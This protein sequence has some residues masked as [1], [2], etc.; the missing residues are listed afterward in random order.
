MGA[1]L[2]RDPRWPGARAGQGD[3][4]AGSPRARERPGGR[5]VA[6]VLVSIVVSIPACH[7]GDRG[8][9]PRRGG[10][11]PFLVAAVAL[12]PAAR[13]PTAL[14]LVPPSFGEAPGR[15]AR[16]SH[17]RP[18]LPVRPSSPSPLWSPGARSPRPSEGLLG[19]PTALPDQSR[20]LRPAGPPGRPRTHPHRLPRWAPR[21]ATPPPC[22]SAQRRDACRQLGPV[23]PSRRG[24]W[25]R[26]APGGEGLWP[27]GCGKL[28]APRCPLE[29]RAEAFA[30]RGG[31]RR[32]AGPQGRR[33]GGPRP[34]RSADA[35]GAPRGCWW[36]RRRR[37]A[38]G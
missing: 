28:R 34:R 36:R 21:L 9:I 19:H 22:G 14:R 32:A 30:G 3:P 17:R 18:P 7:A 33:A 10:H 6:A 29:V 27:A 15:C 37:R 16:P 13:P 31:E 1:R 38:S 26:P 4:S 2:G 24:K 25:P 11:T 20:S 8:S 5:T 23:S 12:C 35:H